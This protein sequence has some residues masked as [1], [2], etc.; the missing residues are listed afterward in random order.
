MCDEKIQSKPKHWFYDKI[1]KR[2]LDI[3]F[4]LIALI[5]LSPIILILFILIRLKM[6]SPV[7]FKQKRPGKDER[8]FTLY[9]FRSM[10]DECD[11]YGEL[12]PATE[13]L[14]PFGKLLRKTSLDELPELFNVLKGDMSL[15]GPRPLRIRYLPYYYEHE[16]VRHQV[17]PGIT[18]L[19]Q[20][21]GRN[22]LQWDY[23]FAYDVKYVEEQSLWLDLKIILTIKKFSRFGRSFAQYC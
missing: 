1:I 9:K 4:S 11:E 16:R 15:V 19:A 22:N 17:R 6:G 21:S 2:F 7:I 10:T 20:V 18:G 12:L 3:V 14:T 23:R 8:I 5:L 13:R